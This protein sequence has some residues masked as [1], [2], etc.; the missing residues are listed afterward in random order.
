M[1]VV[2][3]RTLK[4][5]SSYFQNFFLQ[6]YPTK[7]TLHSIDPRVKLLSTLLFVILAVSTFEP[8]KLIF[9]L[10]SLI[11][12]SAIL[13]LNLRRLFSRVWLFSLFSFVVVLPLLLQ[14]PK[15]PFL[16]TLR[17]LIALIS[18]QMLIMSS[19]FA[20]ICSALR[21]LKV[22]EVFVQGLWL[23]YRY[24]IVVFQDIINILLARES[25]R[26]SKGSHM[27]L[28]KRG[29]ESVGLFFLRSIERAE[30][31]QLAMASRGDKIFGVRSKFGILEIIYIAL[32]L[33]IVLWCIVL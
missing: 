8:K 16:F 14:D 2:I 12:I 21:S 26:V 20:E 19:S 25:R 1:H 15:Y 24:I 9:L 6:D 27:D 5:A 11:A 17:V 23:A 32:S 13:G 3:E 29:G 22:P 28:W 33:F 30:R 7:G 10:F 4:N 18:V 31:V